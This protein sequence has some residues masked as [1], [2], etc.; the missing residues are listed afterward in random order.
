MGAY[1]GDWRYWEAWAIQRLWCWLELVGFKLQ[2]GYLSVYGVGWSCWALSY[3]MDITVAKTANLLHRIHKRSLDLSF[4][5]R[6]V[7]P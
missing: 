6:G 3:K 1:T 4:V 7:F 5:D 2:D